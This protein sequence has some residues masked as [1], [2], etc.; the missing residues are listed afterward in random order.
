MTSGTKTDSVCEHDDWGLGTIH[1]PGRCSGDGGWGVAT[2]FSFWSE[3]ICVHFEELS[4]E[5]LYACRG[6]CTCAHSNLL[7]NGLPWLNPMRG[8][9]GPSPLLA[10]W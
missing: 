3:A 7:D 10:E 4:S 8:C 1:I 5:A 2:P 6:L 9:I